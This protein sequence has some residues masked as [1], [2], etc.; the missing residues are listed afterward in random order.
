MTEDEQKPAF[1]DNLKRLATSQLNSLAIGGENGNKLYAW[2]STNSL[3]LPYKNRN[4]IMY[5]PEEISFDKLFTSEEDLQVLKSGTFRI[6]HVEMNDQATGMIVEISLPKKLVSIIEKI[7]DCIKNAPTLW[8][9]VKE[10]L[11]SPTHYG[12]LYFFTGA[13]TTDVTKLIR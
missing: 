3:L 9:A 10:R 1:R 11:K 5:T 12:L 6:T 8:D 4:E 2:G 13:N 7:E